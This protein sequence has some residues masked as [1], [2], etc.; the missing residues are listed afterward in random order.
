LSMAPAF[1]LAQGAEFVD[2]DGPLLLEQDRE[3]GAV[4]KGAW[5]QPPGTDVWG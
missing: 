4:Y 2:L 5:M 3:P 1:L